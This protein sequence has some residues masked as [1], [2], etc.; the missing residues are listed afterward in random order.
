M[1][2]KPDRVVDLDL[3]LMSSKI[4]LMSKK[5]IVLINGMLL[6]I[7]KVK[8]NQILKLKIILIITQDIIT[9]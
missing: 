5:F 7:K 1:Q 3:H 4:I 9:K 8:V 6:F 2:R